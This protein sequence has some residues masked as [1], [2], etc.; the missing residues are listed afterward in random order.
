[1]PEVIAPTIETP[2]NALLGRDTYDWIAGANSPINRKVILADGNWEGHAIP[3]EI[4]FINY[5]SDHGYDSLMCVFFNGVTDPLEYLLMEMMRQNLIP[6][7]SVTW[8][9]DKGYFQD[10]FINFNERFSAL[11]GGISPQGAYQWTGANGAKNCGLIP[12]KM[13]GWGKSFAE[14]IDPSCIT[15]E[16]DD[17]GKEF[18]T[19]FAINY[20]WVNDEDTK[21]FLKYSPLSCIGTYADGDGILNPPTSSG[22][23]MLEVNETD[24]YR[25]I[26]DSYWRQFKKYNKAKLQS[27]MAF[28]I[29][30]LKITPMMNTAQW[31]KDNQTKWVRN[32]NTDGFGRVLNGKLMIFTSTD[33]ATLALL[34]DKIRTA[35]SV[36][37]SQVEWD[38]LGKA[39]LIA[40]F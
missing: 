24:E 21:E 8:L 37:I 40:N 18:L 12:Q 7:E 4:Q 27:F 33:R 3:N 11:K 29:T 23:C 28:Y 19:H 20:E 22:H 35:P 9:K 38:A 5:G 14:N 1:M 2:Q 31:I 6:A 26:D 10:G 36:T 15:K 39:G 32:S 17:L 30:P 13:L 34:D 25:A 16:M